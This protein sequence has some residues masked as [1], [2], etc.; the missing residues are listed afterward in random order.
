MAYNLA[1]TAWRAEKVTI[2]ITVPSPEPTL[3]I[4]WTEVL[5][6]RPVVIAVVASLIIGGGA[7]LGQA[8]IL[9]TVI[10][11]ATVAVLG[12][13]AY[14]MTVDQAKPTG[15]VSSRGAPFSSRY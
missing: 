1:R 5:F 7:F 3:A 13:L 14:R 15:T 11:G 8:M 4:A 12:T 2:S 6:G 9:A 10:L